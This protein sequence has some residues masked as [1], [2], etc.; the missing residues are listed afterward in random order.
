MAVVCPV[1]TAVTV[2][3]APGVVTA[4]TETE[5][6]EGLNLIAEYLGHGVTVSEL[7]GIYDYRTAIDHRSSNLKA[8]DQAKFFVLFN[9]LSAT[10]LYNT[11]PINML[12]V[13]FNFKHDR[14]K[15]F[16][17]T[18]YEYYADQLEIDGYAAFV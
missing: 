3:G 13:A 4:V 17:K 2:V 14:K 11:P 6:L 7:C 18:I 5:A 16:G 1:A 9:H 15:Y 10:G 12:E 8:K